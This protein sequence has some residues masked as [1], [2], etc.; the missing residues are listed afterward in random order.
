MRSLPDAALDAEK[1]AYDTCDE[2]ASSRHE[3]EAAALPDESSNS[4]TERYDGR[5]EAGWTRSDA[6]TFLYRLKTRHNVSD[7]AFRA[8]WEGFK[9]T[10]PIFKDFDSA[11]LP[12]AK[13]IKR[14]V[15]KNIPPMKLE[16]AHKDLL[17]DDITFETG[18]S[19]YPKK[20]YA[21]RREWRPIYE[22][23]STEL[24]HVL[25]FHDALHPIKDRSVIVN[26]DG[27]P[28]G[29]TGR[30]Q[31]VVS[32]KFASCR[33]VYM[34]VNMI[35]T[36]NEGKKLITPEKILLPLVYDIRRLNVT[37]LYFCADSPMRAFIRNQ[38]SHSGKLACD[39][40]YASARYEKSR[41]VWGETTMVAE[42]RSLARLRRDYEEHEQE[43]TPLARFGYN[44]R[45]VLLEAIPD[46][47]II[48]NVPVDPMHHLYLGI[49][50][51]LF[52]LLFAVGDT[53]ETNSNTPRERV[54]ALNSQLKGIRVPVEITRRPRAM[55][56]R[57]YKAAEWRNLL[58]YYFPVVVNCL[59]NGLRR[60]M[61]LELAYLCRAYTVDEDT[62]RQLDKS[63][64][65]DLARKWFRNYSREFG[66][67]NLRYIIHLILH[68]EC[69]RVHGPF[70]KISAFPFEGAFGASLRSQQ[71]GTTSQG[72]QFLR[73]SYMRPLSGHM[74]KKT[75]R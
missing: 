37:L 42:E 13:T 69:I 62:Y 53:R 50:R 12:T 5:P 15:L 7:N 46:F 56:Y 14:Q 71:Q 33:N 45:C 2:Y 24:E 67:T 1:E 40:C 38:K 63:A 61:W 25:E 73:Q 11:E 48:E 27:V 54:D 52:E 31:T 34:L 74:C 29:R 3:S 59:P 51:A 22:I 10:L 57:N 41:L 72:L 30:S 65:K 19:A 8:L 36:S 32:L 64:L 6:T 26:V 49:G 9:H 43:G 60:Q 70:C 21:N 47:D 4:D 58:L 39:Y 17:T 66:K 75:I 35:P 20:K 44:G 23:W 55:D 18:L 68:L 16:I 28:I